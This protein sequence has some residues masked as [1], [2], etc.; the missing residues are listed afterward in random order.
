MILFFSKSKLSLCDVLGRS[1]SR[2]SNFELWHWTPFTARLAVLRPT[3]WA[4][5]CGC[6]SLG[7]F[8]WLKLPTGHC[9]VCIKEFFFTKKNNSLAAV[10]SS[11]PAAPA[12]DIRIHIPRIPP[13]ASPAPASCSP[14]AADL[15]ST[16]PLLC[17]SHCDLCLA[18][19][20]ARLSSPAQRESEVELAANPAASEEK[21][22]LVKSF[23]AKRE[24]FHTKGHRAMF[25]FHI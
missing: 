16:L 21:I 18:S 25:I 11:L 10:Y 20:P 19:H 22:I 15:F 6:W 1:T 3:Q 23:T 9:P 4:K 24:A 14:P 5:M 13:A 12:V 2:V 17:L 8:L 7:S